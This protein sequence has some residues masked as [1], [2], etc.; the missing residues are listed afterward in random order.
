MLKLKLKR[1]SSRVAGE[2]KT[3]YRGMV[4]GKGAPL[5]YEEVLEEVA[6]RTGIDPRLLRY[7]LDAFFGCVRE[8]MLKDGRTR[9]V[10]EY[11]SLGMNVRGSFAEA[12]EEIEPGE[13]ELVITPHALGAFRHLEEAADIKNPEGRKR[14]RAETLKTPGEDAGKVVYGEKILLSGHGFEWKEDRRQHVEINYTDKNGEPVSLDCHVGDFLFG[15]KAEAARSCVLEADATHVLMEW[16]SA[17]KKNVIGQ[18]IS[19]AYLDYSTPGTSA[20][21]GSHAYATVTG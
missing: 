11:L 14:G 13:Q 21:H 3:R 20:P 19:V 8:L 1:I 12:D 18:R 16:P 7:H 9:K 5:A 10:G 4:E 6:A 15:T 17:L 2:G